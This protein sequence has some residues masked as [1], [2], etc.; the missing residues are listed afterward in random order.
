MKIINK[1]L[2]L[3][4][5]VLV[6]VY[7]C[8]KQTLEEKEVYKQTKYS[9]EE[10]AN[11]KTNLSTI[12]PTYEKYDEFKVS[13]R[14]EVSN[15]LD[16]ISSIDFLKTSILDG[17]TID[18][19]AINA[20]LQVIEQPQINT[21]EYF[22]DIVFLLIDDK[23][24]NNDFF[25][26]AFKN[27]IYTEKQTDLFKEFVSRIEYIEN[28]IIFQN[29]IKK[30]EIELF[31]S[32]LAIIERNTMLMFTA[33]IQFYKP[34]WFSSEQSLTNKTNNA[35]TDCIK[36]NKKKIFGAIGGFF[37]IMFLLC[38]SV[39]AANPVAGAVCFAATLVVS[40]IWML[41]KIFTTC[42]MC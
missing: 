3:V 30:F 21:K 17:Q 25:D 35:C 18:D 29:E 2:L 15:S 26:L 37:G 20:Y 36:K 12:F 41:V 19:D 14:N 42:K 24:T 27:N 4:V 40:F 10:I 33:S 16:N 34:S 38:L 23:S 32:D 8:N 39:L 22:K 5:L 11:L 13:L 6:S 28:D 7:S 31:K 9:E 1:L